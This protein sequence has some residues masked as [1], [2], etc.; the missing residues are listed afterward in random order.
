[1]VPESS[2]IKSITD[3]FG[4]DI[5]RG[6]RR[7]RSLLADAGITRGKAARIAVIADNARVINAAEKPAQDEN[8]WR[9]FVSD[10][11][12]DTDYT[13]EKAEEAAVW[14]LTALGAETP[15]SQVKKPDVEWIYYIDKNGGRELYKTRKDGT[16]HT[17]LTEDKVFVFT[18]DNGYIYYSNME[19]GGGRPPGIYRIDKD[20]AGGKLICENRT[21]CVVAGGGWV[22][23]S[24]YDDNHSLY[25]VLSDG[26]GKTKLNNDE[27]YDLRLEGGAIFYINGSDR[28]KPY[29]IRTDGTGRVGI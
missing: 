12:E 26:G 3:E 11:A 1:M 18:E 20:G 13:E 21:W 19:S 9:Q 15:F 2:A 22:Y 4:R 16:G 7:F 10:L 8:G 23:F 25:R 27:S 14:V 24:N 6:G 29:R 17:K 28:D 5:L